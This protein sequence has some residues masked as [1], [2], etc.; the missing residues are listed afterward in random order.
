MHQQSIMLSPSMLPFFAMSQMVSGTETACLGLYNAA[1]TGKLDEVTRLLPLA[2]EKG[3]VNKVM[4]GVNTHRE[5]RKRGRERMNYSCTCTGQCLS[6]CHV[7]LISCV[8][9]SQIAKGKPCTALF[10]AAGDGH[11]KVVSFL[12]AKGASPRI[13][14]TNNVS[15]ERE[16]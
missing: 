10:R 3:V 7:H 5:K 9:E 15:C 12:L 16:S 11:D 4:H 14:Y 1:R 6:Q 8:C 2:K 13:G